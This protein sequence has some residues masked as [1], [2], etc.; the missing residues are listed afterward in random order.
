M[1]LF[2]LYP[3]TFSAFT[4]LLLHPCPLR[5]P[6]IFHESPVTN[7]QSRVTPSRCV[8]HIT[9]PQST[10]NRHLEMPP[11]AA[12]RLFIMAFVRGRVLQNPMSFPQR[13]SRVAASYHRPASGRPLREGTNPLPC[14]FHLPS[15]VLRLTSNLLLLTPNT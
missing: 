5:P 8:H 12:G 15:Y 3:F 1:S 9:G 10:R 4:P 11:T 14:G 2:T 7:H 13:P 6:A